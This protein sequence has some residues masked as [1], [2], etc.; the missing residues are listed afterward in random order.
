MSVREIVTIGDPVLRERA[1]EL[2]AEELASPEIQALIDDLIWLSMARSTR[3][4]V[5]A[6]EPYAL[7]TDAPTTDSATAPSISPTRSRTCA[8]SCWMRGCMR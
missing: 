4:A 2:S 1:R 5:R 8:Y 6:S 7:I 3:S